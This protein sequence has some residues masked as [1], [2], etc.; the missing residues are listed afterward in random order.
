MIRKYQPWDLLRSNVRISVGDAFKGAYLIT[1]ENE[2]GHAIDVESELPG[3][4]SDF[5]YEVISESTDAKPPTRTLEN[6]S[7]GSECVVGTAEPLRSRKFSSFG[8]KRVAVPEEELNE[9][10]TL[11]FARQ[12]VLQLYYNNWDDRFGFQEQAPQRNFAAIVTEKD[13]QK[14]WLISEAHLAMELPILEQDIDR[15]KKWQP[16]VDAEWTS[17]QSW[18]APDC[19]EHP[20]ET[21]L[22]ELHKRLEEI[23]DRGYRG[24]GV[25]PFYSESATGRIIIAKRIAEAVERECFE[26][27]SDGTY[28]ARDVSELLA[29]LRAHL[30]ERH[31]QLEGMRTE[32]QEAIE[33]YGEEIKSLR[34]QWARLGLITFPVKWRG[35]F[36]QFSNAC[37]DQYR[38]M[39]DAV[40]VDFAVNLIPQVIDQI[41]AIRNAVNQVTSRFE[42]GL[43]KFRKSLD[44][45]V[46]EDAAND[47]RDVLV[48]Y[49]DP[50]R[51]KE[52]IER[53]VVNPDVQ[54]EQTGVVRRALLNDQRLGGDASFKRFL[55]RVAEV[56]LLDV[57]ERT[58]MEQAR[59]AH[60]NL[61]TDRDRVLGVQLMKRLRD[62]YGSSDEKLQE[63]ARN[64]VLP[65]K[66]LV[67]FDPTETQI[68]PSESGAPEVGGESQSAV[69]VKRPCPD[70]LKDFVA[71]LDQALTRVDLNVRK[72]SDN[73]GR[74]HELTI[75]SFVGNFPARWIDIV[76]LLKDRYLRL[77]NGNGSEL[78]RLELHTEDGALDLP[79]LYLERGA[80]KG[81]LSYLYLGLELGIVE[82]T[83]DPVTGLPLVVA[84]VGQDALPLRLGSDI[85]AAESDIKAADLLAIRG[86]I[87]ARIDADFRHVDAKKEIQKKLETRLDV[88]RNGLKGGD[89][90]PEFVR[91]RDA[92][93]G[94]TKILGA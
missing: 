52:V 72:P 51:V 23:F 20:R 32:I 62:E 85:R 73:H 10:L 66:T 1:N 64:I 57:I 37:R 79:D 7:S 25:H 88:I 68:K 54:K 59:V 49:Y 14:R 33:A 82:E 4:I 40:A 80:P 77:M 22:D 11:Q 78:S 69:L 92:M 48:R 86:A 45:R 18:I 89:L 13:T 2:I 53:L 75:L 19:V 65:A 28:S 93:I 44:A 47:F 3:V 55:D 61:V 84:R 83:T 50:K 29:A 70:E 91:Y 87:D 56:D 16:S 35:V 81:A 30:E 43:D 39:T 24:R 67:R 74:P 15:A 46:R 76:K 31:K 34:D 17:I 12:S 9:Y 41:S 6:F 36:Q 21:R 90:N 5:L 8:I 27:W 63:F 94:C 58:C 38:A 42:A 71:R 60:D 26:K